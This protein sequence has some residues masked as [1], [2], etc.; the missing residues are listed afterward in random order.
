MQFLTDFVSAINGFLWGP[1]MLLLILGAGLFLT[2]G[3]RFMTLRKIGYAFRQLYR[4]RRGEVRRAEHSPAGHGHGG[5]G[6]GM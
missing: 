4:G 2:V 5:P 6:T 3:L 1:P